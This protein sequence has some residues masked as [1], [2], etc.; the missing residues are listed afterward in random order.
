MT[1][2][3]S[4]LNPAGSKDQT[5][6]QTQNESFV[7]LFTGSSVG[8][9]TTSTDVK[10]TKEFT[11][12]DEDISSSDIKFEV[13]EFPSLN[14]PYVAGVVRE[15][16]TDTFFD[17]FEKFWTSYRAVL[18][19]T[20]ASSTLRFMENAVMTVLAWKDCKTMTSFLAT[21]ILFLN[22][23]LDKSCMSYAA[24]G[25]SDIFGGSC[26]LEEDGALHLD[27]QFFGTS[28]TSIAEVL[29]NFRAVR[30]SDIAKK[31]MHLLSMVVTL[32]LI[33][34]T[35]VDFS[36]S[37][38]QVFKLE[39]MRKQI[40]ASD[41][42]ECIL[43]TVTIFLERGTRCFSG[44]GIMAFFSDKSLSEYDSEYAEIVAMKPFVDVGALHKLSMDETEYDRRLDAI[45]I[46]TVQ[47][48]E[49]CKPQ[50]RTYYS[51]RLS[52]LRNIRMQLI[53]AQRSSVRMKPYGILLYGDSG[54][55]KS[56]MTNSLVRY[57]LKV[58]GYDAEPE[59]IVTLNEFDQFQSEYR[60]K[61]T[62]VI[63][64][65]IANGKVETTDG[66]P[67][68]KVVQFLNNI[69]M[70][71]LNPIAELKANI[72]LLPKVVVGNTNLIDINAFYYSNNQY[73]IRR[74][75]ES[76][77]TCKVKE[78]FK[79]EG[80]HMIDP[81][82]A[83][84]EHGKLIPNFG[85]YTVQEPIPLHGG[86][87]G[88]VN[89]TFR[90][91]PLVDVE[92][93][94]LLEF[95]AE[96][97]IRHF[98]AQ[99]SY[100]AGQKALEKFELCEHN[101]LG[102]YCAQ[103]KACACEAEK[104][105]SQAAADYPVL[106]DIA[107]FEE[108]R[109]TRFT[110]WCQNQLWT[111]HG[112]MIS[113]YLNRNSLSQD[114]KRIFFAYFCMLMF[115]T[116]FCTTPFAAL[117]VFIVITS[118]AFYAFSLRVEDV[119][120]KLYT[121]LDSIPLPS[122][123][124]RDR[125]DKLSRTYFKH[126]AVA[127]SAA[128][129]MYAAFRFFNKSKAQ[130]SEPLTTFT[131]MN[132]GKTQT[133][134]REF[135][136][137]P[138]REDF[139][140]VEVT[141][142]AATSTLKTMTDVVTNKIAHIYVEHIDGKCLRTHAFP[143]RS[144]VWIIPKH[145]VQN[146]NCRAKIVRQKGC[147]VFTTLS[148]SNVVQ[149]GS[150]DL[151]VW[152]L[153]EAGSQRD[154][155]DFFPVSFPENRKTVGYMYYLD[156]ESMD[157]VHPPAVL[158]ES[159]YTRT[160]ESGKWESFNYH[161]LFDTFPGLCIAPVMAETPRPYI[162]GFHLAGKGTYGACSKVTRG[163]IIAAIEK[164]E[165][166]PHVLSSHNY[167]SFETKLL[168]KDIGPLKAPAIDSIVHD[169]DDTANCKV[170][171]EHNLGS[172]TYRS[173]VRGLKIGPI[174]E[175][176]M[177]LPRIHGPPKDM[178]NKKHWSADLDDRAHPKYEFDDKF[179]AL[180]ADDYSSTIFSGL[181]KDS[182][183]EVGKVSMD[184]VLAGLD[185]VDGF[186]PM[187]FNTSKGF[188]LGGPKSTVVVESLEQVPG[189]SCPR[190]LT[191]PMFLE[192]MQFMEHEFIA[193][194]RVNV[195]F[196][197]SLKDEATKLTKTKL[198]M[199]GG[200]EMAFVF[201]VRK[202]YL[203]LSRLVKQHQQLFECAVGITPQSPQW[204]VFANHIT[205]FGKDRMIAGD[206]AGFDRS[207]GPKWT[208]AAFRIL[209]DIAIESGNYDAE[210]IMIMK[211]IAS[212]ICDPIYDYNGTLIAVFGSNPSGH[213]LTVIIN[214][215]VNSLYLRYCYYAIY[216]EK[217]TVYPLPKFQSVVA[218]MTYGDDNVMGVRRGYDWYNHT[219]LA[220]MFARCG[221]TYT[222]ADKESE[223]RPFIGLDEV[224]FLKHGIVWDS[225]IE[226]Y[227]APIEIASI[228]K[229]LHNHMDSPYLEH[230]AACIEAIVNVNDKFFDFGRAEYEQRRAQLI[231]ISQRAKLGITEGSLLPYDDK[232][233]NFK[234]K[235]NLLSDEEVATG[236]VIYKV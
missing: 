25:I 167:V 116:W 227:R 2:S 152:Y 126:I 58:N 10:L 217:W 205:K 51:V 53:L 64:D 188:P 114:L 121:Q 187:D 17:V 55:G 179:I 3:L 23:H 43:S 78:E 54:V 219:A 95:L 76:T 136:S 31:V 206:Y 214:S 155:T 29:N 166:M 127:V 81:V 148:M 133:R 111:P 228:Q 198:R 168:G 9:V 42:L 14:I 184:V 178:N 125:A 30:D 87:V 41:F 201:L 74:R 174:V 160:N 232:M 118:I 22:N 34:Q 236:R 105:D 225:A 24:S 86:N 6:A 177:D 185:G 60:T 199:F 89:R 194:R 203:S 216:A 7:Q 68:Q 69:P 145:L 190:D 67:C 197:G 62:G 4:D 77:I 103:C 146:K 13:P 221:I 70:A 107:A 85:L 50:E 56:A 39:A 163:E 149:I 109:F 189:I 98:A 170:L 132:N 79:K 222:M 49:S 21:L 200:C 220:D 231:E 169:L 65:D 175:E 193:G 108:L 130:M 83:Q 173:S 151:V 230:S 102:D 96:D 143:I 202:Y 97:S 8:D 161:T 88:M 154:L 99:E 106:R 224:S 15:E 213:P 20:V 226:L 27:S 82:K 204:T 26:V 12:I 139:P 120:R 183:D 180:A 191:D 59:S 36:W 137:T 186:G 192:R 210:D 218:A 115:G 176:I 63:F 40:T 165:K 35:N 94:T 37:G 129:A 158:L 38:L 162:A 209:I 142:Q 44:E 223:S 1:I 140:S 119:R 72:M 90:G 73:S 46:S 101:R 138:K 215:M 234:E 32:G 71:A 33:K 196:K 45:T 122:I 75:F 150:S 117:V 110:S 11:K 171:G 124:I 66:N 172:A 233:Y 207:M 212:E 91:K 113:A 100:V 131:T 47:Y 84:S 157:I 18:Q 156:H 229:M 182:L 61:H 92:V 48:L 181:S 147:D 235:Y 164:L 80:T 159:G 112:T 135:W 153:P 57:V 195:V 16:L 123:A 93:A 28:F 104:L 19:N 208:R 211:G 52:N 134:E 144:N 5:S 128:A 141:K